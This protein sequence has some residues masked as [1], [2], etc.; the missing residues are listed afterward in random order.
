MKKRLPKVYKYASVIISARPN[1]DFDVIDPTT[2]VWRTFPSQ[3]AARWSATVFSRL[4]TMFGHDLA[5][6][7]TLDNAV[8]RINK[9]E[10]AK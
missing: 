4:S 10:A 5:S 6:D 9:K 7:L 2:N 1:G 8:Y 3:R